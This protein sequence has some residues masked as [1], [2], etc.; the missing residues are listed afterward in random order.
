MWGIPFNTGEHDMQMI[1]EYNCKN[2]S[3]GYTLAAAAAAAST[4]EASGLGAKRHGS[5]FDHE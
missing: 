2:I 3:V 1:N 5:S 4:T